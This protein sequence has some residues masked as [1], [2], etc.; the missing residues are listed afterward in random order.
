MPQLC[1]NSTK[2]THYFAKPH[3]PSPSSAYSLFLHQPPLTP[4]VR[5]SNPVRFPAILLSQLILDEGKKTL[6]TSASHSLRGLCMCVCLC[7]CVWE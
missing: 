6:S 5:A 1:V 3:Q 7:M 4:P 2:N